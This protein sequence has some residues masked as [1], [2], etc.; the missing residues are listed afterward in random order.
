MSNASKTDLLLPPEDPQFKIDREDLTKDVE[1]ERIR[2][3]Y[4]NK[5]P[6]D[7]ASTWSRIMF[8]WAY[9]LIRYARND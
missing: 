2:M 6:L 7:T 3:I 8:S 4:A 9:P 1:R 5:N